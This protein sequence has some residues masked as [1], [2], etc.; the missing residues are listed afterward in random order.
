MQQGKN[1]D[2]FFKVQLVGFRKQIRLDGGSCIIEVDKTIAEVEYT[3]LI[4][5]PA[6]WGDVMRGTQLNRHYFSW[7]INQYKNG[8]EIA[9][10]C[11]GAFIVAATGLLN[12]K[13]CA[14]HWAYTNELLAYYPE[15]KLVPEKIIT[16]QNGIYSSGGGTSYWNLLLYLLEKFTSR[17]VVIAATKY[18]LLDLARNSQSEFVMFKGQKEHGDKLV[19]KVQLYIENNYQEKINIERLAT[20][21]SVVRRTL[22]RRFSKATKNTIAEY[23]Q[24]TKIEVAKK[25]IEKDR[26]TINEI[27]YELD[28]ADKKA[29]K[30]LFLKI[31]GL[32]PIEYKRKYVR[33]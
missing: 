13:R 7:L 30:D 20:D 15:I 33:N 24:R 22:E 12:G 2:D 3:D 1:A 29:F 31:T 16:E 8:A 25:E 18:F 9:S 10:Y 6:I 21:F 28:Y 27:M 23:I 11:V 19:E 26:K 17:K 32:T 14:T 5:V 4:I